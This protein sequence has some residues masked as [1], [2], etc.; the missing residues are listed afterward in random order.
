MGKLIEVSVDDSARWN[1]IVRSFQDYE[2]FYLA[3]YSKAFMRE[4]PKN[5]IPVLL[6]YENGEERAINVVFRRDIALD[7]KFH[8]KVESAR[9]YDLISP[10]GYGGFWGN[11]TD[12][13]ELNRA[14]TAY[15]QE[16]LYICEFVRFEL[17][18][19]YS[20]HYDGKVET[21][22]H[23]VV[24]SLDISIEEM[25]MEF[26][27]KVRRNVK[28]AETYQL[29]MIMEP[30][31]AHLDDFLRIYY[32]T[33]DRTSAVKEY[34]F[35]KNFFETLCEMPD[36]VM[37]FYALFEGKIVSAE[38]VLYGAKNGY[39]YLGGT[40]ADYYYVRPNDFLKYEVIKWAKEK[41]LKNYVLGGGYGF[42]DGIFQYKY[43]LAPH[44]VTDF[45]I[46][47]KIFAED[48]YRDLVHLR[49]DPLNENY[50]PL[51]RS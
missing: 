37:F 26:K 33:M 29:E 41:G 18:S 5:G 7:E 42:D 21:R 27:S 47:H 12:W 2:V 50:F 16:H 9:Y 1:D 6:Y 24:R 31:D 20:H 3:E 22:T 51:Y 28:K 32:S 49:T 48:I 43:A 17:F 15:C 19:D 30:N 34:Y 8:G 44:G 35:S 46:G 25:W 23:N 11:I 4:D 36:N 14:Y 40:D 45:Y 10:Y 13:D 38:V 39:F